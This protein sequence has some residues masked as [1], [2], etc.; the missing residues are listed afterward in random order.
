MTCIV[1]LVN[2]GKVYIGSDSAG[3]SGLDIRIRQ[4]PKVF[5]KDNMIFGSTS[6]YRMG[7]ILRSSFV[8]PEHITTKNDFDYL[9]S[10]FVDGLIS[11]FKEK[12]YA[13]TNDNVVSGGE[14]ILGYKGNLYKIES[15]FQV[16]KVNGFY[17][18]CGCGESYALGSLKTME[19]EG[20]YKPRE[21]IEEALNVAE[22]F[23]AGVRAPFIVLSI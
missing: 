13:R 17:D 11:C 21:M 23:S 1:G 15:D 18:A 20:S 14:F 12:G 22:Y 9:C 2:A 16:A 19:N 4:D 7:Q 8:I 10:D 3:V 6:S 5:I